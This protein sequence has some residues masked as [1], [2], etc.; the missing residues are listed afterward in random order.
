MSFSLQTFNIINSVIFHTLIFQK[1]L[2]AFVG[3]TDR[4][5][6]VCVQ[7]P[8]VET[9]AGY[10]QNKAISVWGGKNR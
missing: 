5:S 4:V 9:P 10:N 3:E 1:G 8:G 6:M 2:G 7:D